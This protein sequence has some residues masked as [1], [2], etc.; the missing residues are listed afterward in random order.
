MLHTLRRKEIGFSARRSTEEEHGYP[1]YRGHTYPATGGAHADNHVAP[2]SHLRLHI[3]LHSRNAG[4]RASSGQDGR[5]TGR[6]RREGW[7]TGRS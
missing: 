7:A 1:A 2:T 3:Y 4:L 5:A 6:R